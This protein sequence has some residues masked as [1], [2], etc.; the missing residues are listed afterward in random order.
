MNINYLTWMPGRSLVKHVKRNVLIFMRSVCHRP[1]SQN[2]L[3]TK[4][5]VFT[6]SDKSI[7]RSTRSSWSLLYRCVCTSCLSQ[8]LPEM[9]WL[10]LCSD[11]KGVRSCTSTSNRTREEKRECRRIKQRQ[12]STKVYTACLRTTVFSFVLLIKLT[13]CYL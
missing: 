12:P 9:D 13:S 6:R 2:D 5:I 8:R 10:L 3:T 1:H 4:R 11:W 7:P